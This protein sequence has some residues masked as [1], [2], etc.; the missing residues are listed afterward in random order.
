MTLNHALTSSAPF[1]RL[2]PLAVCS[3]CI[4]ALIVTLSALRMRIV[5]DYL[6]ESKAGRVDK[7]KQRCVTLTNTAFEEAS[8][9]IR[10]LHCRFSQH[11]PLYRTIARVVTEVR[12]RKRLLGFRPATLTGSR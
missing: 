8:S 9:V 5:I 11:V 10:F 7:G 4:Q 2:L 12:R 1:R 6:R 3:V